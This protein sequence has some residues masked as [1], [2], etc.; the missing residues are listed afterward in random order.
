MVKGIPM[1]I[2]FIRFDFEI[3]IILSINYDKC[4]RTKKDAPVAD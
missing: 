1:K 4:R 3:D 2:M